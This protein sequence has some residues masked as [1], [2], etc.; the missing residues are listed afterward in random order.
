[1]YLLLLYCYILS[2]FLEYR[3]VIQVQL[4]E[5][6]SILLYLFTDPNFVAYF[7]Y[8]ADALGKYFTQR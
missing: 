6:G 3:D 5:K 8:L 2:A 4:P 1:M 7:T